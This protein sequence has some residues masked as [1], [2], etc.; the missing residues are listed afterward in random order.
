MDPKWKEKVASAVED[1]AV[2]PLLGKKLKGEF[3]GLSSFRL[4]S[5]RIIF[6]FT[7]D[8]LEVAHF[9]HRKDAYR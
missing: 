1:L 2:N 9:I 8:F 5:Y 7:S 3:E 6:R 4:G